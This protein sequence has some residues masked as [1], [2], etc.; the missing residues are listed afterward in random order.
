ML[1]G[2][3]D[4]NARGNGTERAPEFISMIFPATRPSGI[5]VGRAT[6]TELINCN[7][8][9]ILVSPTTALSFA[10][11]FSSFPHF[12]KLAYI[13]INVPFVSAGTCNLVLFLSC[14]AWAAA[15]VLVEREEDKQCHH[16]DFCTYK[17][18]CLYVSIL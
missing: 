12:V 1:S 16:A 7:L 14:L 3:R 13:G 2:F 6:F 9:G 8:E 17:L 5:T 4:F 18:T 10:R 15:I 11:G